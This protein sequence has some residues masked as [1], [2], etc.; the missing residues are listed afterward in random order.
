MNLIVSWKVPVENEAVVV[1]LIVPL[2]LG[3]SSTL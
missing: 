3:V 2:L 1:H